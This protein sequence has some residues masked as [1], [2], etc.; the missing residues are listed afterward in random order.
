[1]VEEGLFE[2]FPCD[3]VYAIHNWPGM[4]EGHVGLRTGPIMASVDDFDITINGVGGHAAIPHRTVDPLVIGSQLVLAFQTLISRQINPLHSAVLSV[5]QFHS[6]STYNVIAGHAKLAGTIRTFDE[7]T[8]QFLFVRL[9]EVAEAI[10]KSAGAQ[11]EVNIIE[12]SPATVNHQRETELAA[13]VARLVVGPEK[14]NTNIEPSMAAE[15]FAYFLQKV[16]GSYIWLGHGGK[17]GLHNPK[18]DFNDNLLPIGASWFVK[19][20][21]TLM[22]LRT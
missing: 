20:A 8:R 19:L 10:C 4:A 5:T 11:V 18:Y 6:G 17:I 14:V 9:K 2:K 1:M 12:C 15:D 22:P 16:P 7:S 3:S 13:N 21:E